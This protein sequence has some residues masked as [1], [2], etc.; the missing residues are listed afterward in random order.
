M[1]NE[2]VTRGF[3]YVKDEFGKNNVHGF[4]GKPI[5]DRGIPLP[6]RSTSC[7]AGYDFFSPKTFTIPAHGC[8]ELIFTDVKAYMLRDERLQLKCRSKL[9][10]MGLILQCSGL[11]DADYFENPDN[12]GNIGVKFYNTSNE[13]IV[14]EKGER[15]VQGEFGKFLV[16]DNDLPLKFYREGGFGSTGKK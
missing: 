6:V 1:S 9:A 5:V 13:D 7:S 8:S 2:R 15:F 16:A 3:D 12:D 10:S 4:S 14:I 11:I